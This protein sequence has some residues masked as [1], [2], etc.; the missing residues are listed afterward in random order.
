MYVYNCYIY[1]ND[2]TYHFENLKRYQESAI[3]YYMKKMTIPYHYGKI[4]QLI[5]K[6][7]DNNKIIEKKNFV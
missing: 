5:S 3:E 7:S 4:M 6:Q 2:H 1:T